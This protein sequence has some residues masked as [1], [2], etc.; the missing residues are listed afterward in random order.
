[1]AEIDVERVE[2]ES[3][4]IS[5]ARATFADG[6]TLLRALLTPVIMGLILWGWQATREPGDYDIFQRMLDTSILASVL[7]GVAALSDAFDDL[8]GGAETAGYRRFGWFDDIADMILVVGTLIALLIVTYQSGALGL[9]L[10]I[11]AIVI[12]A[13]EVIVGLVK[14]Y[15]FS[16]TGWPDTIWGTIKNALAMVSTLLLVAA[17]WLTNWIDQMRAGDDVMQVFAS[18]S[19]YIWNIGLFGLWATAILSVVTAVMLFARPKA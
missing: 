7:F 15:E 13:R 3:A 18:P 1:M 4:P 19:A 17:P 10:A 14:G 9:G 8:L 11:P 12:I 6:L 2:P 5:G 16:R